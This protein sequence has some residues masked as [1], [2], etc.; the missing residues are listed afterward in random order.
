MPLRNLGARDG[1]YEGLLDDGDRVIV[2]LQ[3]SVV[4]LYR[5]G[6]GWIFRVG[7]GRRQESERGRYRQCQYCTLHERL[8]KIPFSLNANV[9]VVT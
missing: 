9:M 2:G 6:P 8:H 7:Q 5:G 1:L 4:L 3:F